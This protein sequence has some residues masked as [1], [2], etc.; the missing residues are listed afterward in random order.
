MA[1]AGAGASAGGRS[2]P[3]AGVMAVRQGTSLRTY[4]LTRLALA[5]PTVLILLTMVF[6][7][8][9]VAPA[10][11]SRRR[12][13]V[14]SRRKELRGEAREAA[15][16]DRP[17]LEQYVEYLGDVFTLNLGTT[18]TDHRT[19]TS[20]IVENGTAT[21]ELTFVAFTIALVVGVGDRVGR[22]PLPRHL[23]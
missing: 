17:I 18:L 2:A 14:T 3:E 8:M 22:G 1:A 13:A 4:L 12:W 20:I 11:R 10:T 16:Y 5:I 6:L 21:L 7:L 23:D 9:R 19:V 15:G